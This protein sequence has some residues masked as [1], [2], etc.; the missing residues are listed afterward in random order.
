MWNVF[1]D[2]KME[3]QDGI[4][5]ECIIGIHVGEDKKIITTT[6]VDSEQPIIEFHMG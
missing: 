3:R 1:F 4:E 5:H 6:D 2:I